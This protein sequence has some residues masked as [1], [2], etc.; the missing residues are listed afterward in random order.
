MFQTFDNYEYLIKFNEDV[1]VTY[2]SKQAIRYDAMMLS[3]LSDQTIIQLTQ[4][5]VKQ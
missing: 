5:V 2:N 3:L 1:C 4:L